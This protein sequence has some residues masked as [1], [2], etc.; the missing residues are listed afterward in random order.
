MFT[1]QEQ[2]QLAITISDTELCT[3]S[4]FTVGSLVSSTHSNMDEVK[5]MV[6]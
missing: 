5:G 3:L 4:V 6:K 1:K 2:I